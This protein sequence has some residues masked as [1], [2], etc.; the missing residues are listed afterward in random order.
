MPKS[1]EQ[2]RKEALER[3][4]RFEEKN[5]IKPFYVNSGDHI[6]KAREYLSLAKKSV[7]YRNT[8][9]GNASDDESKRKRNQADKL[10]NRQLL[11]CLMWVRVHYLTK[12]ISGNEAGEPSV[13]LTSALM[14][15][16]EVND[17][18]MDVADMVKEV[19]ELPET[20][21][22]QMKISE[23]LY[24]SNRFTNNFLTNLQRA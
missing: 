21:D 6:A 15:G 12:V 3:Q 2:K 23:M 1:K 9:V 18:F 5:T 19:V 4:E 17:D 10:K 7:D 14:H 24:H 16:Y 8:V 11:L 13:L 20:S 22:T